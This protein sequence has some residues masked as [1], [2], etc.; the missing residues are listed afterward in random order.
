MALLTLTTR[1]EAELCQYH[2]QL[3]M[4]HTHSTNRQ[5]LRP[6]EI[7]HLAVHEKAYGKCDI[8]TS[9][10]HFWVLRVHPGLVSSILGNSFVV[11]FLFFFSLHLINLQR[12]KKSSNECSKLLWTNNMLYKPIN[13]PLFDLLDCWKGSFDYYPSP[14]NSLQPFTNYMINSLQ[15]H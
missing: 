9:F 13:I 7:L 3:L 15:K 11:F 14:T 5:M 1:G 10:R 12:R 6:Q 8:E 2:C 4:A